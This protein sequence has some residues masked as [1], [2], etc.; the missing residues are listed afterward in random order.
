MEKSCVSHRC[1]NSGTPGARRS[2][3]QQFGQIFDAAAPA[4]SGR[5]GHGG[6]D[7]RERRWE[8]AFVP[9]RSRSLLGDVLI[10]PTPTPM[11]THTL[12]QMHALDAPQRRMPSPGARAMHAA[13][14]IALGMNARLH[15]QLSETERMRA[16][17]AVVMDVLNT[18]RALGHRPAWAAGVGDCDRAVLIAL[19]FQEP[20]QLTGIVFIELPGHAA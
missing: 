7:A 4:H 1:A 11:P 6:R 19:G 5:D 13:W 10:E 8:F 18:V 16:T 17:G 9:E 3:E 2:L 15:R 12:T 20:V 14:V